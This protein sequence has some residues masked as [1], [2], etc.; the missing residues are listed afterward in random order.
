MSVA[1]AGQRE[2]TATVCMRSQDSGP[3]ASLAAHLVGEEIPV[4]GLGTQAERLGDGLEGLGVLGSDQL[5]QP[6]Q[7]DRQELRVQ[8]CRGWVWRVSKA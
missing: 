6:E 2:A 8:A 3:Q 4:D 7:A 1:D 5:Q